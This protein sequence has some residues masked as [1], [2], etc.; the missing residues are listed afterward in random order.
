MPVPAQGWP[1]WEQLTGYVSRSIDPIVHDVRAVEARLDQHEDW[2]RD[3]LSQQISTTRQ[4]RVA[5]TGIIVTGVLAAATLV[6][7]IALAVAFHV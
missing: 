2:H 5:V 6:A 4:I 3:T 1:S 7:T